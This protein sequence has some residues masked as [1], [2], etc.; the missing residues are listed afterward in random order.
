MV[1]VL[2]TSTGGVGVHVLSLTRALSA[3]GWPVIV[4]APAST[5]AVFDFAAAGASTVVAPIGGAGREALAV[6][7]LLG[8]TRSA[9]LVHAHG[10]R[11]GTAA[12]LTH[13]VGRTWPLITTWHNAV[14]ADGARARWLARGERF[15]ARSA[16]VTLAASADLADRARDLGAADVREVPVAAPLP[17]AATAPEEVRAAL[18]L[19][20]RTRLVVCV[21]R[22]HPQ[23]G[24]DTLI[25]AAT[26]WPDALV[27]IAGDGPLAE[28]LAADIAARHAPVRLLGRRDNVADLFAAA[29]V[30]V[31]ASRWEAR[32]L[33]VQE[34][35]QLG[36]PVVA[37]D[38]GGV[39]GLVGDGAVIVAPGDVDALATAVGNLL[40]DR[41]ARER[42]GRAAAEVAQTW[43]D[44]AAA[45][46]AVLAVY[47][48]MLSRRSHDRAARRDEG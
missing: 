29:D 41:G 15:V 14:L 24:H 47:T 37:T 23:K 22:L 7:A 33:A 32:P 48:E 16:T 31:L 10:L 40:D 44:E 1:Q 2:A 11:A 34:A 21:G 17:V 28:A 20:A 42:L 38:V 30:V 35:M 9:G 45:A 43:P 19:R 46:S 12:G 39:R 27:V 5:H 6:P 13:R 3:A 25:A 26:R 4:A 8:A 18:G 36:R